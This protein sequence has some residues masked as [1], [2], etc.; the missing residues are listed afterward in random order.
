MFS[1]EFYEISENTFFTEYIW[2]T[3]SV[4]CLSLE[5]FEFLYFYLAD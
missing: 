4:Y 5:N 1:C 2:T 3:A